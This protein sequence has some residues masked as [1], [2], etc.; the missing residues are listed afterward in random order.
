MKTICIQS[1]AAIIALG[2]ILPLLASP[3]T[4]G[5]GKDTDMSEAMETII[6]AA[7]ADDHAYMRLGEL[8]DLVGARLNGSPGMDRA[9]AFTQAAMREDGLD[10]VHTETVMV[11]HWVRGE[12][13][14]RVLSPWDRKLE[15]L[16]LGG[17]VGTPEGGLTAD[18]LVVRD[19]D[20]LETRS[21]EAE[22]RIVLFASEWNGYGRT[23][24][25]RSRGAQAAA[26]HGA[27]ACLIR[28]VTDRSL[29]TTHTGIMRY[30]DP[31]EDIPRIPAAA[32]TVEDSELLRRQAQRGLPIRIHMEMGA[33]IL[34]DAASANVIGE[35]RGRE[36]PE[37]IVLVSGHLDS[38]DVGT[39][40][41]D[42]GTGVVLA[43]ECARLLKTLDMRP[44]RTIRVVLWA[45]E[46][47][48][49]QGG[50][51]YLAGHADE[52]PLHIAALE[53]DSGCFPPAGFSVRADSTVADRLRELA[54]P[55][56]D[57]GAAAIVP[58]W[59]GVDTSFIVAEGVPGIGHRVHND[60]YFGYHHSPA[61]TF[62]KIEPGDMAANVAAITALIYAI[63]EAEE[64]LR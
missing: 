18:V 7:L 29:S 63:A 54:A 31:E 17:S 23:V 57:L 55:L 34:P 64:S 8:C 60:P 32:I 28:S 10:N 52:L 42:D 13:S 50:R 38:W 19:F 46:E 47:M 43:M 33:R 59:S 11:P 62:D 1:L 2:M 6:A 49:Q 61:D 51:A 40:A 39:C 4:A 26:R 20:E 35:L 41:H 22:G 56:A 9:I 16:G 5:P 45:D 53:S 14:A 24:Q 30:A 25:Y 44:R 15:I 37:E 27:V 3:S 48:T 58:G 36:K 21:A 12:E